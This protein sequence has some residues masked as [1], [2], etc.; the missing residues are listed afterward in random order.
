MNLPPT[1][2][3]HSAA[4]YRATLA[5]LGHDLQ[6]Y[7]GA[8]ARPSQW[9]VAVI[10]AAARARR[11]VVQSP[12]T[13]ASTPTPRS[14]RPAFIAALLGVRV[15]VLVGV[16]ERRVVV[17][18]DRRRRVLVVGGVAALGAG[19]FFCFRSFSSSAIDVA[20]PAWIGSSQ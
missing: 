15:R 2:R 9:D 7:F 11:V 8:G 16:A 17:R 14:R 10:D 3:F 4:G 6:A 19:V 1:L 5:H 20:Y 13:E 12:A 18:G